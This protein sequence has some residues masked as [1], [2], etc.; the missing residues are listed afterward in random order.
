MTNH[1]CIGFT[2]QFIYDGSSSNVSVNLTTG[3][4]FYEI[5]GGSSSSSL[6]TFSATAM[7]VSGLSCDSGFTVSSSLLLLGTLTINLGGTPPASGTICTV[8]GILSY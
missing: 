8:S 4:V 7:G 2:F 3:P 5:P 1:S 6:G